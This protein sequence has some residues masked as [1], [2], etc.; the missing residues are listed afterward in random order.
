M[1]LKNHVLAINNQQKQRQQ[2]QQQ[3]TTLSGRPKMASENLL[4]FLAIGLEVTT[5]TNLLFSLFL[6]LS[7]VFTPI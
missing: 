3:Q 4:L 2:Q 7:L 6:R 1:A 5:M